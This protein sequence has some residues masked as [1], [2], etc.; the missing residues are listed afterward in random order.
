[1][2]V[3]ST[4]MSSAGTTRGL[5]AYTLLLVVCAAAEC[6]VPLRT[7]GG[8]ATMLLLLGAWLGW[9]VLHSVLA[10]GG[11]RTGQ[12]L[13]IAAALAFGLEAAVVHLTDI[14]HHALQPQVLGVPLQILVAWI[15]CLYSGFA[16]TFAVASP[17]HTWASALAF[18][19]AAGL[20]TTALGLTADPVAVRMGSFTYRHGGA[21]L[22]QV[23]GTNGAHGIPLISY[24]AWILLAVSTYMA[25]WLR[26]RRAPDEV[27]G[28][29]VEAA[30]FYIGLFIAAAVP[31][32]R[33]GDA[34]LLVIGGLPVALVSSLVAYRLIVDRRVRELSARRKERARVTVLAEHRQALRRR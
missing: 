27:I 8:D 26:T 11:Q 17:G 14:T 10:R 29:G 18:S 20:V 12:F 4:P 34:Q 31:A 15:V 9:V 21:F 32:V 24:L 13:L 25:Y 30:L 33:L 19:V 5:F 2:E 1:M 22:P 6:L 23:E 28:G 16:V 7:L 3:G